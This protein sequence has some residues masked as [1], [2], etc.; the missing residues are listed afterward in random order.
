MPDPK[1]MHIG[2]TRLS[3]GE[4]ERRMRNHLCLYCGFPGHLRASCPTRPT[5]KD[6]TTVSSSP[7]TLEV[8][9]SL[10]I[11]NVTV[12][13]RALIDSGAAGNFIDISF[14]NTHNLSLPCESRL[15]VAALDTRRTGSLHTELVSLFAIDSPQSPV[16]LALPWLERHNPR[17]PGPL[18]G[19][20]NRQ[21]LVKRNACSF[22]Q[23][24]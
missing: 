24:S 7:Y 23:V 22:N 9:I 16:I 17:F 19:F 8:P 10:T 15:A 2:V 1:P 11:T 5:S 12:E 4:R 14:A 20:N 13:M 3:S 18:N 6:T 21:N